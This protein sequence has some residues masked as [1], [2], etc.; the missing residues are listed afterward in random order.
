MWDE[1]AG[2]DAR[3]RIGAGMGSRSRAVD[4][5]GHVGRGAW[6]PVM[7]GAALA[8]AATPVAI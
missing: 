6:L 4:E 8:N 5:L 7:G 2:P 1:R 3:K